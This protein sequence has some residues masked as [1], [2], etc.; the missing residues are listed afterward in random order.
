MEKVQWG[1]GQWG[2]EDCK[3][4]LSEEGTFV[5]RVGRGGTCAE[6]QEEFSLEEGR[7]EQRSRGL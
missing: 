5:F 4:G 2:K 7:V 1:R 3:K 6:G